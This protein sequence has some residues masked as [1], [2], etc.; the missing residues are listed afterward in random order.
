MSKAAA[1]LIEK[2][3]EGQDR[4]IGWSSIYISNAESTTRQLKR[5]QKFLVDAGGADVCEL[6]SEF[7]KACSIVRTFAKKVNR[8]G[9]D[10]DK[11]NTSDIKKV[12]I[13]LHAAIS[14]AMN[15]IEQ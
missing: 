11:M 8:Y 1:I 13:G 3:S 6:V 14:A 7:D 4:F 5:V 10:A 2:A 15:Q 12:A 9:D